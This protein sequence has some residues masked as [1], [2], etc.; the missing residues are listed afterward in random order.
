ML[1]DPHPMYTKWVTNKGQN[2]FLQYTL[3]QKSPSLRCITFLTRVRG[4]QGRCF[5]QC[6]LRWEHAYSWR[7]NGVL[8]K[9]YMLKTSR[10]RHKKFQSGYNYVWNTKTRKVTGFKVG[11]PP[12]KL[13]RRWA[14]A[15][16]P[17]NI[18]R[19]SPASGRG[20]QGLLGRTVSWPGRKKILIHVTS[21]IQLCDNF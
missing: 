8:K 20:W 18:V 9:N 6:C 4:N 21:S 15:H 11:S 14:A 1:A 2:R 17:W 16:S 10:F 5:L 7:F 13:A 19:R 3:S 12:Q